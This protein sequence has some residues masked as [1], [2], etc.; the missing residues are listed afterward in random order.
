LIGRLLGELCQPSTLRIVIWPEASRAQNN[1]AAVSA[2]GSTVWVLIRRLNSS[3]NRSIAF[4][5]RIDFHWS[6]ALGEAREDEQLVAR[7]HILDRQKNLLAVLPDAERDDR[8]MDVAFLSSRTRT[9]VPSRINQTI[10]SSA[11]E[12]PFQASQSPFTLHQP[13]AGYSKAAPA[14]TFSL[15]RPADRVLPH[16]AAEQSRER[17]ADPARVGPGKIGSGDQRV[18]PFGAPLVGRNGRILPLGRLAI[19]R[20]QTRPGHT[21]RHRPEGSHQSALAMAVPVASPHNRPAAYAGLGKPRPFIPVP[22]QRIATTRKL[23]HLQIP[24]NPA[25]APV[26]KAMSSLQ[27]SCKRLPTYP[28]Q[29]QKQKKAA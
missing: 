18:G 10:G 23:R 2:E 13:S 15:L 24:T 11:S 16:G 14:G 29:Q 1:I 20:F 17:P 28:Q 21:H 3:C 26:A 9:T 6:L 4:D 25:T 8:E 5:V 7:A 27:L 12:R 22:P 19:R